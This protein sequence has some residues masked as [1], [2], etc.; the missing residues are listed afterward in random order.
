MKMITSKTMHQLLG[1]LVSF[2]KNLFH[3]RTWKKIK[4]NDNFNDTI[5]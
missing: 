2:S 4:V 1:I 5:E 3:M